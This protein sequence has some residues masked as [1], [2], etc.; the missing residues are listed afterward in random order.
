M[1]VFLIKIGLVCLFCMAFFSGVFSQ[2]NTSEYVV[3]V[4]EGTL[5]DVSWKKVVDKLVEK[6]QAMIVTYHQMTSDGLPRLREIKPRYVAVVEKPENVSRDFVVDL[7]RMSREVDEDIYVD[8]LWGI[9]TGIDA[10]AALRLVERAETSK[11]LSSAWG[12][13]DLGGLKDG[14]YFERMGLL[15]ESVVNGHRDQEWVEKHSLVEAKDQ[16]DLLSQAIYW[17]ENNNPD[18]VIWESQSFSELDRMLLQ[19]GNKPEAYV[20][21]RDG[22]LWWG[23]HELRLQPNPRVCL[24]AMPYGNSWGRKEGLPMT[25]LDCENVGALVSGM[26]YSNYDKGMLGTLQFWLTG[27]GRFSLAEAQFLNQ[28]DL[29]YRLNQWDASLL[30]KRFTYSE[31]W[32]RSVLTFSLGEQ[33]AKNAFLHGNSSALVAYYYMYERDVMVYYGDPAWEVTL[34]DQQGDRPYRI[35]C[36]MKGKKCIVTIETTS[37]FSWERLHGDFQQYV[38]QVSLPISYFFPKRLKNPRLAEKQDYELNVVVDED[39]LFVYDAYFKPNKKYKIV[40][41]MD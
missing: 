32:E 7:N 37:T 35:S 3:L 33:E 11:V 29:T 16:P 10:D 17:G 27:A 12:I 4:Q 23:K 1:K 13:G 40:L 36:K 39:F 38:N 5:A 30:K 20:T 18:I 8:F 21:S 15:N 26:D 14:K 25:C 28:Q 41:D 34:K 19:R 6:H 22:K 31:R 2:T 9:I 24:F